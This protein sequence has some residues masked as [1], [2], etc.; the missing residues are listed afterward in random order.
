M[1][2]Q[3][4]LLKLQWTCL[5]WSKI[6]RMYLR[7]SWWKMR[8]DISRNFLVANTL[9]L[10]VS[11]MDIFG[12]LNCIK[13]WC[14]MSYIVLEP[15]YLSPKCTMPR[16]SSSLPRIAIFVSSDQWHLTR[17]CYFQLRFH[18]FQFSFRYF[19]LCIFILE[20]LLTFWRNSS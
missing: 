16:Y 9:C 4:P 1:Y 14:R 3:I 10:D 18:Y 5:N 2:H 19:Q 7:T 8:R 17:I 20:A 11:R 13:T 6:H 15:L 12:E